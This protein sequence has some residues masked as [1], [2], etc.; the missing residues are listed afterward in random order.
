[1]YIVPQEIADAIRS[2]ARNWRSRLTL[3]DGCIYGVETVSFTNGSQ[4]G[5]TVTVG[6]VVA[7]T[8]KITLTDMILD[9]TE[10]PI[11]LTGREFVWDLGIFPDISEF[12]GNEPNNAYTYIP[13]GKFTVDKVKLNGSRYEAEC[14]HKLSKA[15]TAHTSALSFPTDALTLMRE[16]VNSLG[17]TFSPTTTQASELEAVEVEGL[18]DGA[19]KRDI[20]GWIGSLAGGFVV[21][22][23][24]DNVLIRWYVNSSY[25]V[26]ANA[27]SEPEMAEQQVTYTAV[28]CTVD[29]ATPPYSMGQGNAMAFE[30]PFMTAA[31]FT[32][33]AER[34]INFSYRPCKLTYLLGDPLIDPWDI[35]GFGTSYTMPAA[36]M[37][38]EHKG[39]VTGSIE[40]KTGESSSQHVDP[41][42]K[43]V[44]RLIQMIKDG[45]DEIEQDISTAIAEATEAIRGGA[46]GYFY[47]IADAN[48]INKETIWCDNIN[49]QLATHGIRINAAGIGFWSASSG[50][51]IFDGPYTQ[52]WTIDGTLIADFI[53]AGTLS[54]I[55]IIC[56]EGQIGGWD[57]TNRAIVSPDRQVRLDSTYDEPLTTNGMLRALGLTH[58][59]LR[60]YSHREVRYIRKRTTG[61]AQISASKGPETVYLRDA[62]L[63][64]EN[65]G[66]GELKI[67]SEGIY[68][69]KFKGSL[70]QTNDSLALSLAQAQSFRWTIGSGTDVIFNFN[71]QTRQFDI[72][73]TLNT[74]DIIARDLD[75]D[76][77]NAKKIHGT[78]LGVTGRY[79]LIDVTDTIEKHGGLNIY[80]PENVFLGGIR[81]AE[82]YNKHGIAAS[83]A[84]SGTD[85]IGLWTQQNDKYYGDIIAAWFADD[86][87]LKIRRP[88]WA[89]QNIILTSGLN[90]EDNEGTTLSPYSVT[91]KRND[92]EIGRF[93]GTTNSLDMNLLDGEK[94]RWT[95][96][97]L[98]VSAI[99]EYDT[100]DDELHIRRDTDMHNNELLNAVISN[101]SDERLKKNISKCEKDCLAVIKALELIQ[102]DWKE[103]G[104]HESIGFSAQQAGG[105]SPDLEGE[106]DGYATIKEGRLIRYLVGAVQQLAKEVEEIKHGIG[107]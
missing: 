87:V 84:S 19:T 24:A 23:R 78:M 63:T 16:V 94:I 89:R 27:V 35:I 67:A 104:E 42:T 64:I 49:P 82:I 57:I 80:D 13:L 51:N 85:F 47:I 9:T 103:S 96:G 65:S 101:S 12:T 93:A 40:A 74:W 2:D 26:P 5:Q 58:A 88:V 56:T 29:S 70:K 41:I 30:C 76:D 105:V 36:T 81:A 99:L 25:T 10:Q 18:P 38:L 33:V 22:D 59:Q 102:F 46:S 31:Q 4:A 107:I 91:M 86:D 48:G 75:V 95:V 69:W 60:E 39:G 15:D 52:A 14:S 8:I 54:G 68:F 32:T 77:V 79:G 61:K 92:S 28:V 7:P 83:V 66:Q 3:S 1:M 50:G 6:S 20:M 34:L 21:A 11:E 37:T 90:D 62:A 17:L 100:T 55:K 72:N 45:K 98:T 73:G 53:K 106:H 44:T 97:S 71:R 43:A